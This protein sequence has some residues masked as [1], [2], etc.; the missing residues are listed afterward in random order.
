MHTSTSHFVSL[1][2][3]EGIAHLSEGALHGPWAEAFKDRLTQ[4]KFSASVYSGEHSHTHTEVCHLLSG[5]CLLSYQGA[6]YKLHPGDLTFFPPGVVHAE[7]S[8]Q[9]RISYQLVWWVLREDGPFLQL[10]DYHKET[11]FRIINRVS[12]PRLP[13]EIFERIENL[14]LYA[15][16]KKAP[17]VLELKENFLTLS[18]EL[19]RYL[20]SHDKSGEIDTRSSIIDL[21]ISYI[22]NHSDKPIELEDV[23]QAVLLSPNYLTT[24]FRTHTGKTLDAFIKEER[25]KRSIRLLTETGKSVKE[26]AAELGFTDQFSFSRTFKRIKG[27]SPLNFRNSL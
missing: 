17:P 5:N 22:R 26:I 7:T 23:G 25:I 12:L 3:I 15:A 21:A 1:Q 13:S 24:L 16:G 9:P 6:H 4:H 2:L 27:V 18:L 10:T 11:G 8:Y 19:L 20:Q 14:K